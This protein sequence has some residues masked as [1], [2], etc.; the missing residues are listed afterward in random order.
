MTDQDVFIIITMVTFFF[1]GMSVCKLARSLR[2]DDRIEL[3]IGYRCWWRWKSA[4]NE[5]LATSE[6]FVDSHAATRAAKRAAK[7]IGCP[8]KVVEP[9]DS[10][11]ARD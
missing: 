2:M 10:N 6:I 5:I 7:A 11:G 9:D 4:N 8:L 3:V 1:V